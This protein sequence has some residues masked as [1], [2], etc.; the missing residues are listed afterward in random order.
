MLYVTH[1]PAAYASSMAADICGLAAGALFHR[2]VCMLA[3]GWEEKARPSTD[4]GDED[5]ARQEGGEGALPAGKRKA[6]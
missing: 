4:H 2:C 5:E 1:Q 3:L 6:E